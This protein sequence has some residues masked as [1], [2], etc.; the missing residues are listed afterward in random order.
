MAE[1]AE[2]QVSSEEDAWQ[3][4]ERALA[5]ELTENAQPS[6]AFK[7][8][9]RLD[10]YLPNVEVDSSLSPAMME[11]LV[12]F[13]RSIYRAHSLMTGSNRGARLTKAEK[14]RLEIR[15]KV[16]GGSSKLGVDL[17]EIAQ[18]WG[19]AAV[20]RMTPEQTMIAILAAIVAIAGVTGWGLWLKHRADV[21]KAEL[22]AKG[23][24]R[25]FDAFTTLT[26]QD[27]KRQKL[28]YDA[29]QAVPVLAAVRKEAD[30]VKGKLVKAIAEEGGGRLDGV[31]LSAQ[32]ANDLVATSRQKS[33]E[34]T[35]RGTYRV[36]R[37]DTTTPD[38]FRVSLKDIETGDEV[39]AS[40]MDAL[41]SE[42]H[43][44]LIRAAEWS[45][46][47]VVVELNRRISRGRT[48]KATVV[49]VQQVPDRAV[50]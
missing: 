2:M 45:K 46:Q 24:E 23:Q 9:P 27:T 31:A 34:E 11:A 18:S 1:S 20:G 21:R 8:W 36:A 14:D 50:G 7:G 15:V 16:Q 30:G 19:V 12:E 4:L 3:Y 38:G 40:L 28:L 32:V 44:E 42:R 43:R 6:I 39:T 25:L 33:E 10:I 29:M 49:D 47:P 26:E 41:I 37:V 48:L 17:T 35:A 13:Q 22:D 5:G